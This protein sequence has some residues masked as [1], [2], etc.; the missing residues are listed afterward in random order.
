MK[1]CSKCREEKPVD[2]FYKSRGAR[3]KTCVLAA[4][5]EW[6]R[7][8]PKKH[9]AQNA[10]WRARNPDAA[11]AMSRRNDA[12]R[13]ARDPDDAYIANIKR[14]Y[15]LSRED[16]QKLYDGQSG[17][18]ASCKDDEPA[19]CSRRFLHVDHCHETGR[20]RGLLCLA[21][22]VALGKLRDD[23]ARIRALLDYIMP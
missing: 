20:V 2:A 15:G 12:R 10:R 9:A 22:N 7:K 18:C 6:R 4:N 16:Y 3:C 13:P 19:N 1:T 14:L 5:R 23:P 17:R 21:C 11:L 8:N